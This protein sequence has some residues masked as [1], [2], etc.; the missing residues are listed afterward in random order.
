[1]KDEIRIR[2]RVPDHLPFFFKFSALDAEIKEEDGDRTENFEK[3]EYV[4]LDVP[5]AASSI[6][7]LLEQLIELLLFI[8]TVFSEDLIT[9]DPL[10]QELVFLDFEKPDPLG[11]SQSRW[12]GPSKQT[13]TMRP[14]GVFI[15]KFMHEII[16][17]RK[18]LA[19]GID[20]ELPPE[21]NGQCADYQK[22]ISTLK[23]TIRQ[24][25]ED[26]RYD[27]L[28]KSQKLRIVHLENRIFDLKLK[29][30]RETKVFWWNYKQK[31]HQLR[32]TTKENCELRKQN[33]QLKDQ[34]KNTKHYK[35]K[36]KDVR[37]RYSRSKSLN[38]TSTSLDMKRKL[39]CFKDF[40]KM[41][42]ER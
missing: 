38:S 14:W 8:N 35:Q 26:I 2:E 1:M 31:L 16:K 6:F 5:N 33:Q 23:E 42:D 22:T 18:K 7:Y 41:L 15:S 30:R 3:F 17:F 34:L 11:N 37:S 25:Q 39:S 19:S 40:C 13:L 32:N 12:V 28:T 9:I 36:K 24:I 29:F 27:R 20:P 10:N 21:I 4:P